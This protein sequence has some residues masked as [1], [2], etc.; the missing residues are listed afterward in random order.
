MQLETELEPVVEGAV[1]VP[2]T[3]MDLGSELELES[4]CE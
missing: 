4:E 3:S 1:L 2:A